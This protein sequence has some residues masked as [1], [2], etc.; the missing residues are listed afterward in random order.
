[1]ATLKIGLDDETYQALMED[2]ARHLRPA[3]WHVKAILR[4]VLGLEFPYPAQT[5]Q[6]AKMSLVSP[7]ASQLAPMASERPEEGRPR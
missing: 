3:D 5:C 4:L 7:G 2:A 1:M 6:A